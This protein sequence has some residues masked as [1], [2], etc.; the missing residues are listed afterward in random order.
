MI[1][2]GVTT[3]QPPIL[4]QEHPIQCHFGASPMKAPWKKCRPI[5]MV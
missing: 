3:P 2:K 5:V 1:Y 4:T